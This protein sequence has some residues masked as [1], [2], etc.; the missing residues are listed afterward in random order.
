MIIE[1]LKNKKVLL[2]GYGADG[3]ATEAY[4]RKRISDINLTIV[5]EKKD[6]LEYLKN[7]KEYEL[8]IVSPGIPKRLL[9]IPWESSTNIFFEEC[10]GTVI[11]ITGTKGKS[12]T[13]KLIYEI[14]KAAA[15]PVFLTGNIG[16]PLLK[17]LD[18]SNNKE[19]IFVA[20]LSSYQLENCHYSPPIAVVTSLFPDHAPHHGILDKYFAAKQNI[21]VYQK[22]GDHYFYPATDTVLSG[23]ITKAEKH[24]I[25]GSYIGLNMTLATEVARQLKIPQNVID[26]AV[27]SFKPLPHRLEYVGE[28]KGIKFY[29]D[30]AAT[31]PEATISAISALKNIG[32]LLVGGQN[33]DYRFDRLAETI[34]FAEIKNIVLFP[35]TGA[36]IKKELTS[37]FN[38]FETRSMK[39]AVQWAYEHTPKGSICLLSTAS[40]SYNLWKNFSEK[41]NE[42]Q[43]W[44]KTLGLR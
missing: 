42:F 19:D 25:A 16:I 5:D 11:G 3:K 39:E 13:S 6:G 1:N 33:R 24:A 23:W 27:K 15:K 4:L 40:T 26:S 20:E 9:L 32:T 10:K 35:E 31:I 43:K 29:D 21:V 2:V 7:Q 18:E 34:R 36:L 12:T 17:T 14:L 44:V 22:V 41:G 30:G 37:S 8:A 38:F 28:F